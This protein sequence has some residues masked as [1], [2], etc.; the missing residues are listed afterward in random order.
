VINVP[1]WPSEVEVC[2]RVL[3]K[4]GQVLHRRTARH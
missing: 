1:P 4:Q 2:L 3:P